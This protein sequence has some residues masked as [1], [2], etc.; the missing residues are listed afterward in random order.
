MIII[1]NHIVAFVHAFEHIH[2]FKTTNENSFTLKFEKQSN[3]NEKC[4]FCDTF[5][6]LDYSNLEFTN[7]HLLS[8]EFSATKVTAIKQAFISVVLF[9]KKSRSP[10]Q[11][12]S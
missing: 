6:S 2:T 3:F 8:F 7:F 11:L 1:A 5:L 10:P 4:C 12:L 9:Q